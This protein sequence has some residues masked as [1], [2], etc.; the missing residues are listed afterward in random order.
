MNEW[1]MK[2]GIIKSLQQKVTIGTSREITT[3]YAQ[4]TNQTKI[5]DKAKINGKDTET[6]LTKTGMTIVT[7]STNKGLLDVKY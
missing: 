7:L 6:K 1:E 3:E 5:T 4:S 2:N